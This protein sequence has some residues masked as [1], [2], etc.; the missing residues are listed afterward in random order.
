[1]GCVGRPGV[2]LSD[3]TERSSL[4]CI[5]PHGRLMTTKGRGDRRS[6]M[7]SV[8]KREYWSG[9]AGLILATVGSAIG[10]GSIWK[11]PYEVGSNGGGAFV[12]SYLVGLLLIVLPLMLVEFA[13]GRRGTSDA[14]RS[15][16]VVATM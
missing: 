13:V 3:R 11:F 15:V 14:S 8:E 4:T 2:E 9:R 10:L 12:L 16:A 1:M 6:G 5:N 7:G